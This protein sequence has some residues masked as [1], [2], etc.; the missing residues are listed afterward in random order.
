MIRGNHISSSSPDR[1]RGTR[2]KFTRAGRRARGIRRARSAAEY[3]GTSTRSCTSA[4]PTNHT[5]IIS[6]SPSSSRTPAYPARANDAAISN[7]CSGPSPYQRR[8]IR[9]TALRTSDGSP[10]WCSSRRGPPAR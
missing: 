2:T 4:A 7:R 10:I 5:R 8:S 6:V 9:I 1:S 3:S